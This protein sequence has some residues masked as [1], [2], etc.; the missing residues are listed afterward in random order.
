[1]SYL[2]HPTGWTFKV[3]DSAIKLIIQ[4]KNILPPFLIVIPYSWFAQLILNTKASTKLS[5]SSLGTQ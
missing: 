1:M 5:L 3:T 2:G 4:F